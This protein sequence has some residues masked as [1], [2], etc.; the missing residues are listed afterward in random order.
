MKRFI[1]AVVFGFIG[2]A[3]F[4]GEWLTWDKTDPI[5][6]DREVVFAYTDGGLFDPMLVVR[7]VNEKLDIFIAWN[8]YFSDDDKNMMLARFDKR[9][10]L[11]HPT[12]L[13]T[14]NTALFFLIPRYILTMLLESETAVFR[15][16]PWNDGP[17]TFVVPC[18]EFSELYAPYAERFEK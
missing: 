2:L 11:Q 5:T 10:P 8:E 9:D 14:N 6:D 17:R 12:S 7:F 4:A 3:A 16:T 1:F 18:A 15:A 13:S